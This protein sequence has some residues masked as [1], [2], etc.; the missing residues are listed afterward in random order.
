LDEIA[1]SQDGLRA[2]IAETD[3]LVVESEKMLRR[4]QK[5]RDDDI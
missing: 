2:S 1:A 3:R 5:E 4:H